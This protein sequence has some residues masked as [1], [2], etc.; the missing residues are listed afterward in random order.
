LLKTKDVKI[1][2]G[3]PKTRSEGRLKDRVWRVKSEGD[4]EEEED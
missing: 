2:Q 1:R 4:D 3:K